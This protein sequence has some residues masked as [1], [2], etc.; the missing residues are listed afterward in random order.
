M[1]FLLISF[2]SASPQASEREVLW[3]MRV[4]I[5][6]VTALALVMALTVESIYALWYLCADL[7]YV[8]LFPQ[9]TCVI[10]LPSSNTYGS[11][12]GYIAGL[13]FRVA[14]GEP[15]IGLPAIIRYPGYKPDTH[16]QEFPYKTLSM[17]ISM[18]TLIFVSYATKVLFEGGFLPRRLDVFRC[19][20]N[21]PDEELVLAPCDSADERTRIG[22][23]AAKAKDAAGGGGS[24]GSGGTLNPALKFSQDDLLSAKSPRD[25]GGDDDVTPDE[26]SALN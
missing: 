24:M 19:I 14:G 8:I 5:F 10:Y 2:I 23:F 25:G 16:T 1:F 11:L 4:A 17:L 22:P 3:V 18:F 6:G 15:M 9:L 20:V 26:K 7:V 12:S 13:F 21:I